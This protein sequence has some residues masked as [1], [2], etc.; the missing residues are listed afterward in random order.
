MHNWSDEFS[1]LF[2][3]H[4]LISLLTLS[5]LEIVLGIDNIIFIS[6]AV[7]RLPKKLQPRARTIGLLLALAVRASMLFCI[8]WIAGLKHPFLHI[9]PYGIAGKDLIL[10]GGGLFLLIKTWKE[11]MNKMHKHSKTDAPGKKVND[12][13]SAVIIQIV[14][15]DFVFSFDSILAAVGLSG[16]ILIMVSAVAI[17]MLLMIVFSGKVAEFIAKNPGI[18]MIA[19]V[20]LLVIGGI[21]VAESL[22]DC[23]NT[24]LPEKEQL[25]INK[26]YA[27]LALAFAL[28]VELFNI[29]ERKIRRTHDSI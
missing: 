28:V 15:I 9:G 27:Y 29:R 1:Q 21:L 16:I 25:H 11:I 4:G 23:Y 8:G 18:K 19:L 5:I 2:S 26:N 20:F 13:F 7:N 17:S 14:I 12:S 10:F 6:L 24:T 22:V 3:I